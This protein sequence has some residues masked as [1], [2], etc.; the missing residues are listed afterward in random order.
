VFALIQP[1]LTDGFIFPKT[2]RTPAGKHHQAITAAIK[3]LQQAQ[4]AA[5]TGQEDGEST[6]VALQ[7]VVEQACNFYIEHDRFPDSY[8]EMQPIP[9]LKVGLVTYAVDW[10]RWLWCAA[11]RYSADRDYAASL[12]IARLGVAALLHR[13]RTGAERTPAITDGAVRPVTRIASLPTSRSIPVSIA[14]SIHR[15]TY[16]DKP[17]PYTDGGSALLSPP[18]GSSPAR[19]IPPTRGSGRGTICYLPGWERTIFLQSSLPRALFP[20]LRSKRPAALG[21]F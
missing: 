1:I 20:S 4:Q 11:C 17:S 5:A 18:T 21:Y 13:H 8:E 16:R 7:N 10:G 19:S 15:S 6:F 12:N 14:I 9:L 2:E 3:A